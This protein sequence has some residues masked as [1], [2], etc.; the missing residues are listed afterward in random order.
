MT[1]IGN[2][3]NV[4]SYFEITREKIGK[5]IGYATDA[6]LSPRIASL[7]DEYIEKAKSLIEPSY[8]YTIL[9]VRQ[10]EKPTVFIEKSI[11][12]ESYVI[13]EVLQHCTKAA[14]FALTI[15]SRLEDMT[16]QLSDKGLIVEA[17][18]LDSI[19]SSYTEKAADFVHGIIGELAHI[20][21][22]AISRRFSPGNC[23]WHVSQQK[24][25]F[26]VLASNSDIKLK[27][28][29]LMTPEKSVSGIIGIGPQDG[30]VT[31]CN[32]C[33]ICDKFTCLWRRE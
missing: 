3:I 11:M 24:V 5:R 17:F 18:I 7:V 26:D 28:E 27:D 21:G 23:D 32:P 1:V 13:S 19:G 10:V 6:E 4:E 22:L 9:D 16:A 20:K 14:I 33:R 29:Y 12:L 25:I 8:T 30:E 15:G 31:S 2:R